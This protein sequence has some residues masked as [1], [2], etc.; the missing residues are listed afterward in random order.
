MDYADP[1]KNIL[2]DKHRLIQKTRKLLPKLLIT[3]VY[4][5]LLALL[6]YFNIGCI[7]ISVFGIPCPGCGM[8]RAVLSALSWDLPSAFQL[9]PMFWSVPILYLYFLTDGKL[10]KNKTINKTLFVIIAAGFAV[11]WIIKL[12]RM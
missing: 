3:A 5:A 2:S 8:T 1:K 7:F 11:T 10:I 4:L 9:H 6:K 12:C